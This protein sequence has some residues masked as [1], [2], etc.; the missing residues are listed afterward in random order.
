MTDTPN[1]DGALHGPREVERAW[2]IMRHRV[3][4]EF[5]ATAEIVVELQDK[6]PE[7]HADDAVSSNT[8]PTAYYELDC[9]E[10]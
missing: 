5:G 9:V 10:S 1:S 7:W 2:D 3:K 8:F 6:R 4:A